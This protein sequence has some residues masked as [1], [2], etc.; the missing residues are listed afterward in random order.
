[1]IGAIIKFFN[2]FIGLGS[3]R[4]VISFLDRCSGFIL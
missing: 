4:H 3:Q 2:V 1:M